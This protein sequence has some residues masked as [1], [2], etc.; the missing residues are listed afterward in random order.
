MNAAGACHIEKDLEW[1]KHLFREAKLPT[2]TGR[3]KIIWDDS[4][5]EGNAALWDKSL[6]RLRDLP[7]NLNDKTMQH[8]L[9]WL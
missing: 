8:W 1:V 5:I 7:S 2:G 6:N 4:K 3:N 9:N